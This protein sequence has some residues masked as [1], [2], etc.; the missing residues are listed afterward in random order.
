MCA[1]FQVRTKRRDLARQMGLIIKDDEDVLL[2]TRV[3]PHQVAPVVL[4]AEGK[5]VLRP[6]SFAMIPKWSK[7][8]RP[9]FATHNARLWSTDDKSG[10]TIPIY[11]KTL[12]RGPFAHRHCLVPMTDFFEPIY[13]G[14]YAGNMV[15]FH[16]EDD[17]LMAAAGIWEE[18]TDHETGEILDSFSVITSDPYPF[19]DKIGHDRSPLFI[20]ASAFDAWLK[21]DGMKPAEY[22]ELLEDSRETPKMTVDIDRP[23]KA[24]WE[25]RI[26]SKSK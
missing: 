13:T 5:R 16:K 1:Q 20:K 23:M 22:V 18:W 25:K 12:W 4:E 19:V 8:K 17:S 3:M 24:G 2:E 6:M 10:K 11:D 15:R 14:E 26:S 7:D 9:K 21:P